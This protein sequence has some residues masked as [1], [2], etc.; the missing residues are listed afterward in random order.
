MAAVGPGWVELERP[1]LYDVRPEWQASRCLCPC[2]ASG[3][4]PSWCRH[5][6]ET[7][8]HLCPP[9]PHPTPPTHPHTPQVYIYSFETPLQHVGYEGFTVQFEHG[10]W[11]GEVCQAAGQHLLSAFEASVGG[12][13][14]SSCW[15]PAL[16]CLPADVYPAHF[17]AKG[18]NAFWAQSA[19]NSWVRN[20]RPATLPACWAGMCMCSLLSN[21]HK[22]L[23][24]PVV[25]ISETA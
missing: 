8:R 7:H 25:P 11:R 5:L 18:Y 4:G 15:L 20:V 1:L 21:A 9:H 16:A 6:W 2:C 17:Q 12:S 22:P 13:S 10:A 24:A 14:P 23:A 19:A 3:A